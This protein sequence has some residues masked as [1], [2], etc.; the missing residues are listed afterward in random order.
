[1][2]PAIGRKPWRQI[3]W[4]QV[5]LECHLDDRR[6]KDEQ[7]L[8]EDDRHD[9]G[10]IDLERHVLRPAAIDLAAHHALCVL[11]SDLPLG[12]GDGK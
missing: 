9:A 5:C 7:R 3:C 2:Q 10:V 4:A 12:L 8:G 1:M 6:G 11:D